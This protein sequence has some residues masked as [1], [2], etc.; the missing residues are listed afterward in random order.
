MIAHAK[1]TAEAWARGEEVDLDAVM[2][3]VIRLSEALGG[4]PII[5]MVNDYL[6][7]VEA[8]TPTLKR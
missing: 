6:A 2:A 1:L 3:N 4:S 7:E 5:N 8:Q